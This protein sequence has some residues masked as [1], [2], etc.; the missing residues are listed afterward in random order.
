MMVLAVI[1]VVAFIFGCGKR[2]GS[3]GS[4]SESETPPET[5]NAELPVSEEE[6][7]LLSSLY[8]AMKQQRYSDAATILNDHE[9]QFDVMVSK[10]LGNERYCYFET[11]LD[12]TDAEAVPNMEPVLEDS[13]FTGMVLT[14]YNTVFYGEFV[15]GK[16]NGTCCVIQTMV[17][18]HPRYSYAEGTWKN[19]KMNGEG[20]TGYLYYLDAPASGL[21]RTE[22]R[23]NYRDN[24]LDGEF[25]YETESVTGERLYWNMKAVNGVTVLTPEWEHYPYRKEYMLGSVEDKER[26]YVLSEDKM[27]T[28]LWNNLIIWPEL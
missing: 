24:L 1:V 6:G 14:R 25:V 15:D 4:S 28:V 26:A 12:S 27:S 18:D 20:R 2:S 8:H 23:G 17:L 22:K 11:V 9:E 3:T 16:P 19:G 7:E 5:L 10:N 13:A 21:I